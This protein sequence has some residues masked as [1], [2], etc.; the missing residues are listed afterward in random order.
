MATAFMNFRWLR[1]IADSSFVGMMESQGSYGS[2][3][4]ASLLTFSV[5]KIKIGT[6]SL[7]SCTGAK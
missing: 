2:H 1:H 7:C 3:V 6:H 4:G 5:D